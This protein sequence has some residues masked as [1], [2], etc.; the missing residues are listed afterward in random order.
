MIYK[1]EAAKTPRIGSNS[2][3]IETKEKDCF[4]VDIK[5]NISFFQAIYIYT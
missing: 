1:R 5:D 4:I 3:K 2:L